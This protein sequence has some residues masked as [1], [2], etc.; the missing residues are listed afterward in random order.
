[1]HGPEDDPAL[2]RREGVLEGQDFQ[3]VFM[4]FAPQ[5]PPEREA[6]SER[7]IDL[8]WVSSFARRF[9]PSSSQRWCI[10]AETRKGTH[11]DTVDC[12]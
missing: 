8:F 4:D 9:A 5:E 10:R 12:L 6:R 11:E 7:L 1:M 3:C 2:G